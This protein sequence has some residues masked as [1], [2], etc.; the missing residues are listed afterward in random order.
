MARDAT[1][2]QAPRSSSALTSALTA[3]RACMAV[4]TATF[5]MA[6]IAA[7]AVELL[8]DPDGRSGAW[9]VFIGGLWVF[10]A[11]ASRIAISRSRAKTPPALGKHTE[12]AHGS[13]DA[14][15]HVAAP[16]LSKWWV[17]ALAMVTILP[18]VI[19]PLLRSVLGEGRPLEIQMVLGLRNLALGLAAL[20]LWPSC[21]RLSAAVS[22]C[23]ML[24]AH[25]I[26]EGRNSTWLL[27]PFALA[28]GVWLLVSYQASFANLVAAVGQTKPRPIQ[29]RRRLPWRGAIYKSVAVAGLVGIWCVGPRAPLA[30]L[31]EWVGTS[32]GTGANDPNARGGVND[33]Q[34]EVGGQNPETTGFAE[35]DKFLDSDQ[36]TL[37]DAASDMYGEPMRRKQKQPER[38]ISVTPSD[39]REI[40]NHAQSHRASR[41][42]AVARKSPKKPRKRPEDRSARALFEVYGRTPLHLRMDVLA[43][44]DGAIWKPLGSEPCPNVIEQVGDGSSMRLFSAKVADCYR[45]SETHKLKIAAITGSLSPTPTLL[46]QF[47][48]GLVDRPEFFEWR[49]DGV[50]GFRGRT[51]IPSGTTIETYCRTVNLH[52]LVSEHFANT[53]TDGLLTYREVPKESEGTLAAFANAWAG[54]LPRGPA[55][56]AAIVERLR[57][58][59]EHDS[60]MGIATTDSDPVIEFLT[61]KKKGPD[62]LFASAAVLLLRQ[63]GYSARLALGYYAAPSAFDSW[64]RHT[65]VGETDLHFWPEVLL[66]D[67]N[68]LA[69]EPTPGYEVLLPQPTLV[70][71]ALSVIISIAIFVAE[72]PWAIATIVV[73]AFLLFIFRVDLADAV[74]AA[75]LRLFRSQNWRSR[76][77]ASLR[78]IESRATATR[79]GRAAHQTLANWMSHFVLHESEDSLHA[80]CSLAQA[81]AYG[82][83]VNGLEVEAICQR[84]EQT[85]TLKRFRR[86]A[87]N[88]RGTTA[89]T[90]LKPTLSALA[91]SSS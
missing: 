66:S 30:S 76:V 16:R 37:Y 54:H 32:G 77:L 51:S 26:D 46:S 39:V 20:S 25:V 78:L 38:M 82:P 62:Y 49:R 23:L 91:I 84:A 41:E 57:N 4:D 53:A 83:N 2:V 63:Q 11:I 64:T 34:E 85:W 14:P 44:Y 1:F 42:F 45:A 81:A 61:S 13:S 33:G 31:G 18:I 56:V 70:D 74:H 29:K 87:T 10:L 50:L 73:A 55:Q 69:L 3:C 15:F 19:E 88:A 28:G 40:K 17:A 7:I 8:A 72:N 67:G 89:T 80:L 21:A 12:A 9:R 36:P 71:R 90:D 24:F 48:V 79:Q 43:T 47:R 6:A 52:S 35:T 27:V 5:A 22:L 58:D 59:F 65:P 60:Q 68:W 75:H 86:A